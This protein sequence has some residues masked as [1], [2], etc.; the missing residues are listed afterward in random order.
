M[1]IKSE[2]QDGEKVPMTVVKGT[3]DD[4]DVDEGRSSSS[5][6]IEERMEH[7]IKKN[8]EV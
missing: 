6:I 8:E 5:S 3:G 2:S 7:A 1:W 4:G